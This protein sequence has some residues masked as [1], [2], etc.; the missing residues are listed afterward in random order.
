MLRPVDVRCRT[1]SRKEAEPSGAKNSRSRT[2]RHGRG[3]RF[4]GAHPGRNRGSLHHGRGTA[5]PRVI[6]ERMSVWARG[7]QLLYRGALN[8]RE[9]SGQIGVLT[10]LQERKIKTLFPVSFLVEY[11]LAA[12]RV[13]EP[14]ARA[15]RSEERRHPERVSRQA[16]AQY[17]GAQLQR[18]GSGNFAQRSRSRGIQ[19]PVLG[20]KGGSDVYHGACGRLAGRRQL[21]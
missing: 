7:S 9:R 15:Q 18:L 12:R 8:F 1:V 10:G 14:R 11:W 6:R 5:H 2:A 19:C 21:V 16:L 4:L 17:I 20:R 13:L 3:P